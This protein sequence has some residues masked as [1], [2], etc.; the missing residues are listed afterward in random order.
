V[1]CPSTGDSNTEGSGRPFTHQF[2]PTIAADKTG[3]LAVCFYDRQW[4]PNNFLIDRVCASS[5]NYGASWHN[6]RITRAGFP[7]VVGQDIFVTPDY[8]GDY[9]AVVSD[10]TKSERWIYRFLC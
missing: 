6:S 5:T 7:S 1:V 2:E 9:E 10:I 8:M 3:R 4:D